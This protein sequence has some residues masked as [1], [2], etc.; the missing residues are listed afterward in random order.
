MKTEHI[1]K[2]DLFFLSPIELHIK[3]RC[4]V[5]N[6]CVRR[7]EVKMRKLYKGWWRESELMQMTYDYRAITLHQDFDI[8][9]M[10][11]FQYHSSLYQIHVIYIWM[12]FW[13]FSTLVPKFCRGK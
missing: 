3:H 9:K 7:T 13:R 4:S 10:V 5:T 6:K 12:K 8:Y 2:S 11:V 1:E